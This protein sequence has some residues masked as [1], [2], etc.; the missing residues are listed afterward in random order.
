MNCW[1]AR[2]QLSAHLDGRL[3]IQESRRLEAHLERCSQCR[4]EQAELQAL[5][6]LLAGAARPVAPGGFWEGVYAGLRQQASVRARSPIRG[7]QLWT[8]RRAPVLTAGMAALLLAAVV[9]V[10]YFGQGSGRSGVSVDELVARHAGYCARQPLLEH[11]RMYYVVAEAEL[12]E[13]D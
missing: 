9:P 11:G 5:K 4:S 12:P 10:Q 6:A 13:A 7:W 3:S 8:W 2:N 1:S